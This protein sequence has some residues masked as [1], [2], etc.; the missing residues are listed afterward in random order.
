MT[1]VT[2]TCN[3]EKCQKP[4]KV[5]DYCGAHYQSL[6][7]SGQISKIS[8]QRRSEISRKSGSWVR[9][10]LQCVISGCEKKSETNR[11]CSKHK[12]FYSRFGLTAVQI[13]MILDIRKCESCGCTDRPICIDHDHSCCS[14]SKTCGLCIRG[15]LCTSCNAGMGLLGDNLESLLKAVDYLSRVN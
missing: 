8:E 11:L 2:E 3:V 6:L 10:F 4:R 14:G 15:I 12:T 13:Q 1:T 7:K 9:P 5:R